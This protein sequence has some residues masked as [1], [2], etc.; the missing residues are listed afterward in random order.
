MKIGEKNFKLGLSL[1]PMAG[2][3]DRGMRVVARDFGAELTTTEMVSAKAVVYNDKKTF[4]LAAIREDEGP[5]LLQLFG[6]EPSVVAEAAARLSSPVCE[7]Y[8]APFGIDINMGCPVNKIFNNGE[9]SALMK[10]PELIYDIVKASRRAISLPLTVKMRLGIKRGEMLAIECAK[11]AEEAGADAVCIH[12]RRR[13]DMYGGTVD[14]AAIRAVKEALKIPL[15]ANGDI[16]DSKSALEMLGATGAD[17]ISVGRGAV[18]NPFIFAQIRAA[19]SGEDYTPPTLEE[20]VRV[21]LRQLALSV[22]DKGE[23]C[24]VPESRK[25]IAL[26]LRSFHGSARLRAEI[27]RATTYTEVE[28]ILNSVLD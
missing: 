17:G 12:G 1:A 22:M 10:S 23:S 16:V 5:V 2:Y 9:G 20:R 19:L 28:K 4:S 8:A 6:S 27:N 3:T 25:Q 13:E 15:F 14:M 18:G 11:A 21:A 24:A 26:Y 7:G